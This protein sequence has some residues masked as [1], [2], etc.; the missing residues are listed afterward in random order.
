MQELQFSAIVS[1]A[2]HGG[3]SGSDQ[4]DRAALIGDKAEGTDMYSLVAKSVGVK[5][6]QAKG[7]VLASLYLCGLKTYAQTLLD[8]IE[9][10]IEKARVEPITKKAYEAMRGEQNYNTMRLRNGIASNFFNA[11]YERINEKQPTL[12]IYGQN[13]PKCLSE[14]YAGAK[15]VSPQKSGNYCI[16][17]SCSTNGLLSIYLTSANHW[18]KQANL[19][20]RY[21]TSIHD[22]IYFICK[23][24]EVMQTAKALFKA[25]AQ[26]WAMAH[27]ALGVPDL[28]VPRLY[29]HL[30][31][32]VRSSMSKNCFY[33]VQTPS[34]SAGKIGCQIVFDKT[35]GSLKELHDNFIE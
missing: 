31:L 7:A 4:F 15:Q 12:P 8:S 28:P 21:S 3:C 9:D 32:D 19:S 6:N 16:Q 35:T 1:Q 13:L 10:E 11:T 14:K 22:A 26:T 29:E 23:K 24:S 34:G 25:H 5:R 30:V 17:S 27:E 33:E 20:S 2:Y 18:F